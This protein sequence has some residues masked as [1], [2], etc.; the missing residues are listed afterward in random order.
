MARRAQ[1]AEQWWPGGVQEAEQ[2]AHA[3]V[4]VAEVTSLEAVA[5]TRVE[6]WK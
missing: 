1:G 3:N 4:D 2:W 6:W 5:G